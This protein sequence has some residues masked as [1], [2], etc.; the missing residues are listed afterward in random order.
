MGRPRK[1]AAKR[2]IQSKDIPGHRAQLYTSSSRASLRSSWRKRRASLIPPLLLSP[3]SQA[4]R[5]PLNRCNCALR[6]GRSGF[7]LH[8][9]QDILRN[10]LQHGQSPCAG[11]PATP[12]ERTVRKRSPAHISALPSSSGAKVNPPLPEPPTKAVKNCTVNTIRERRIMLINPMRSWRKESC[13]LPMCQ[14]RFQI[15]RPYGTL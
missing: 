2:P 7:R 13:F 11:K 4:L 1:R 6:G 3:Q 9:E 12:K 8:F 14:R 15:G 5:G 10:I